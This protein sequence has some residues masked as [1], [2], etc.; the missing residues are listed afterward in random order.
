MDENIVSD[1]EEDDESVR[2]ALVLRFSCLS[3]TERDWYTAI[4]S[5]KDMNSSAN[6]ILVNHFYCGGMPRRILFGLSPRTWLS[7]DLL[8]TYLHMLRDSRPQCVFFPTYFAAKL[9]EDGTYDYSKVSN[10]T[11]R[12]N[13]RIQNPDINIFEKLKVFIPINVENAHWV[14]LVV[15]PLD[16]Q[17]EFYDSIY[18]EDLAKE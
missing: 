15:Y 18:D 12:R 4:S 1:D 5:R 6:E 9:I 11:V 14:L 10:F 17:M 3:E 16:K 2:S 7:C 8:N 13:I